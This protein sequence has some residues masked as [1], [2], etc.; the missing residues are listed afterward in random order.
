MD[1]HG[2]PQGRFALTLIGT[3]LVVAGTGMGAIQDG[4]GLGPLV[5]PQGGAAP[6][7]ETTSVPAE[8][9]PL[10][11]T[12]A[13]VDLLGPVA[14]VDPPKSPLKPTVP[15]EAMTAPATTV[16]PDIDPDIDPGID[17]DIAST[18]VGA[19]EP[20]F[21]LPATET[22]VVESRWS[23]KALPGAGTAP[24]AGELGISGEGASEAA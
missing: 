7:L 2:R 19:V 22:P 13:P 17:P 15:A 21:T 23:E 4:P 1:R 12:E 20:L 16:A 11:S 5:L 3:F 14:P 9:T 24:E 10:K 6:A 8:S 18:S